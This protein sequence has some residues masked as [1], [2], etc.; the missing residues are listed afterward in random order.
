MT[1]I[2]QTPLFGSNRYILD[3][4]KAWREGYQ[5]IRAVHC[6][7]CCFVDMAFLTMA[8]AKLQFELPR[9]S[10]TIRDDMGV[11][12]ECVNST[13]GFTL[14]KRRPASRSINKTTRRIA[15]QKPQDLP[16]SSQDTPHI[17]PYIGP[18][19]AAHAELGIQAND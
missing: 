17:D 7:G 3:R 6:C 2:N 13:R 12:H 14:V 16:V 15:P 1:D 18:Q 9:F 5:I 19:I 11:I 10:D 8:S 4:R